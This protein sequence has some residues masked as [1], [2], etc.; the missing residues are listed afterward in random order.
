MNSFQ[1]S[2]HQIVVPILASNVVPMMD[3]LVMAEVGKVSGL[4]G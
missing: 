1:V 2:R 4:V 3:E